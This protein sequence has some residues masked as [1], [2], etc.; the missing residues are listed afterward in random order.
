MTLPGIAGNLR[1]LESA[2][3]TSAIVPSVAGEEKADQE[4]PT[5]EVAVD[6]RD[7]RPCVL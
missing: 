2:R 5:A 7:G 6:I 1:Y 4:N 3:E